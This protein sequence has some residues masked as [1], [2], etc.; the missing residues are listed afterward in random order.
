M[1]SAWRETGLFFAQE[2]GAPALAKAITRIGDD[3]VVDETY[4][5]AAANLSEPQDRTWS[6]IQGRLARTPAVC[7]NRAALQS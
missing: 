1:L 4:A 5:A 6:G 3:H 2:R 7:G